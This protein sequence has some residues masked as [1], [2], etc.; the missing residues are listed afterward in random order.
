M[1]LHLEGPYLQAQYR[2][3]QVERYLR[4]ANPEE[5]LPWLQSGLVKLMTVAP[6]ID[7]VT[8]LIRTGTSMGIKFSVGHSNA[9][10]ETVLESIG[11]GLNQA[12]HTFNAMPP[13][14]H[15]KPSVL[16]AVLTDDRVYCQV[17][18]DGIHLHPGIVKLIFNAKS[19]EKTILIT[20]AIGAAGMPNGNY[21]LGEEPVSVKDGVARTNSGALAGSTL[22]LKDA[23]LNSAMFTGMPWQDL[24]PSATSVPAKSLGMEDQ[25]GVLQQGA[26]ADIVIMDDRLN[27]QLT[28]VSGQ[29]VYQK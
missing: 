1:G 13:L 15:R 18:A 23:L 17:I 27:P 20:D 19:V 25:I 8:K 11:A 14:H 28:M 29:I 6:E 3:A 22:I 12:T 21:N 16:G 9:S 7:G 24:L 10:Y 5:Y 2:G 4:D 26:K